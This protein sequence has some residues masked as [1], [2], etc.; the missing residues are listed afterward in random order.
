MSDAIALTPIPFKMGCMFLDVLTLKCAV[1]DELVLRCSAVDVAGISESVNI[2]LPHQE[3][4]K[5]G[6][7]IFITDARTVDTTI[8]SYLFLSRF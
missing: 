7:V 6:E 2:R 8:H 3:S 5:H 4:F 1:R